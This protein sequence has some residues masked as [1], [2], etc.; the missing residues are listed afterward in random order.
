MLGRLHNVNNGPIA[1][2]Q[3]SPQAYQKPKVDI[4]HELKLGVD[5]I[6]ELQEKLNQLSWDA[7]CIIRGWLQEGKS[8]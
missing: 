8:F 2:D 5:Y 1:C 4:K 3:I 6:C 7:Q